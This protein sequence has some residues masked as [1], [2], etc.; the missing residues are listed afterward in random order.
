[1]KKLISAFLCLAIMLFMAFPAAASTTESPDKINLTVDSCNVR[2]EISESNQFEYIYDAGKY[3]LTATGL[4]GALTIDISKTANAVGLMDMVII[5]IPAKDYDKIVVK[6]VKSGIALPEGINANF[7]I[8]NDGGAISIGIAKGF[9]K[10]IDLT[11]NGGS[12]AV[13]FNKDAT[14]YTLTVNPKA[15]AVA[16]TFPNFIPNQQYVRS[17]GNGKA[18]IILNIESSSFSINT[19]SK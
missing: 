10:N 12:G 1:M 18:K 15:S 8:S 5:K 2:V 16:I 19:A 3:S 6:G 9:T 17:I 7:D 14:D 11:C 13:V 4:D